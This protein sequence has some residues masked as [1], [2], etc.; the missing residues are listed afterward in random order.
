MPLR[1]AAIALGAA[2]LIAGC[3]YRVPEVS[4]SAEPIERVATP[5]AV[6]G[7]PV[8]AGAGFI[9][10]EGPVG[11]A[12][13]VRYLAGPSP[14][15]TLVL[16]GFSFPNRNLTFTSDGEQ[17]RAAYDVTFDVKS[18][19]RLVQHRAARAEVRVSSFRETT[20][21]E[22]SVIAQQVL[23][24][25]PGA[26]S[27]D[28]TVRDGGSSTEGGHSRASLVVPSVGQSSYV[29][30]VAV[31]QATP[32]SNASSPLRA[33]MNPRSTVLLGRDSTLLVYLEVY[34]P[35][36]PATVDVRVMADRAVLY[37]DSTAL[38]PASSFRAGVV[39]LPTARIG[40]GL[41][42]LVISSRNNPALTLADMSIVVRPGEDLAFGSFAETAGYLRF[43]TTP[44][45]LHALQDTASAP[46]RAQ[47]WS[48]IVERPQ[49]LR[50]DTA[51]SY[52]PSLSEY[53]ARVQAANQRFRQRDFPG[54]L[55]DRGRV[56]STLGPPDSV[57]EP[58]GSAATSPGAKLQWQFRRPA[59]HL[60]FIDQSGEG[61]WELT[62]ESADEFA[63]LFRRIT[64]CPDC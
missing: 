40:L 38:S 27:L 5:A 1:R 44:A 15:S 50:A 47:A 9:T 7:L 26:Y 35:T 58:I 13:A 10:S 48:A 23:V 17:Y 64:D 33:I 45:R 2:G 29:S 36:A 39:T 21:N 11:F 55:T 51:H 6:N 3:F 20:R 19:T 28:V 53:L 31:Y 32:R 8:Y 43:F 46:A 12:G 14:D 37:E 49:R 59:I 52:L 25:A 18:G 63:A 34:G 22:E 4:R 54:W 61:D 16:L 42:R 56:Y 62:T 60:V 41:L 57:V 30:A 24:L